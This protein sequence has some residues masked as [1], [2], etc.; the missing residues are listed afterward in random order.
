MNNRWWTAVS[1]VLS[2]GITPF[3][4][5]QDGTK[6]AMMEDKGGM[7][8]KGEMKGAMKDSGGMKDNAA[9]NDEGNKMEKH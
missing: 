1:L 8:G 5:A 6:G 3:A 4:L 9:T 2:F 7:M